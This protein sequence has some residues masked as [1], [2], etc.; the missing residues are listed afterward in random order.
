MSKID[1]VY[2]FGSNYKVAQIVD[3]KLPIKGICCQGRS[4]NRQ[5]Y[6][7]A[8]LHS[9]D[10]TPADDLKELLNILPRQ[11]NNSLGISYGF[12]MIFKN[13]HIASFRH[14][15]W[16]IHTGGLPENRGR[17]PISWSFL[18]GHK[19]FGLSIHEINEEVDRGYLLAKGFIDRDLNDT[20]GEIEEKLI[21]LLS[22]R[23][24]QE[25]IDNYFNSNK[26]L[27][28]EGTYNK[29]LAGAFQS[30]SV[31][32]YDSKF[33]FN[34]F[35]SQAVYGGVTV[36]DKRY[37]ECVFYNPAYR[38]SYSGY[39]IFVCQDGIRVGLK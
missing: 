28:E 6:D 10:F 31:N 19:K 2:F 9:I 36:G 13:A 1:S 15:I 7:F 17:H 39:D 21:N 5:I 12:G 37:S 23:L 30:I 14:G 29:S 35:K 38:Q 33:I 24:F 3:A 27:L 22:M 25:A 26:H 16:N 18:K 34:L 32:D 4:F 20:Q 11:P 8:M